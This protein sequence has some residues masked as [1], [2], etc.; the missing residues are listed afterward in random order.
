MRTNKPKQILFT[1]F[2]SLKIF[3]VLK[4]LLC[5]AQAFAALSADELR[6]HKESGQSIARSLKS[7]VAGS[8]QNMETHELKEIVGY[9]GSNVR[10]TGMQLEE[11]ESAGEHIKQRNDEKAL[12]ELQGE[13]VEYACDKNNCEVGHTFSSVASFKRQEE[14]EKQGFDRDENGMP[15]NNKSYLDKA[16]HAI[17]NNEFDY[18]SGCSS[19]CQP[20]EETITTSHEE[21]CD[22]YYDYKV[23]SCFPKQIVEIDPEYKYSCNKKRDEKIKTCNEKITSIRCIAS[24]ECDMGG[25]ERGTVAS[26]MKFEFEAG[27][28]T[29]GTIADN[30][31]DGGSCG[32]FDRTTTFKVKNKDKIK[33]FMLFKVGFD[34][35]MQIILNDHLIYVGPDGGNKLEMVTIKSW[36]WNGKKVD[37][38]FGR[39]NC[40]RGESWTRE[41]NIDLKPFLKEGENVIKTRV[42]VGGVGEGW[43]QIRAKQNCCTNWDIQREKICNLS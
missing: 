17:K 6:A 28:L 19:N 39:R 21:T 38:G 18:L 5:D 42:I 43:M 14:L 36:P 29:I 2:I 37:N 31:W 35:Y 3:I 25:I 32:Q 30:Y 40:E 13:A 11:A 41:P 16:L 8:F 1:L 10:G 20:S 4:L 23:D 34:D 12:K 24:Q 33:E 27:V 9:E 22:Q 7:N 15:I 26:D